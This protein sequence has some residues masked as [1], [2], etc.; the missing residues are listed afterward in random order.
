MPSAQPRSETERG[1]SPRAGH[2]GERAHAEEGRDGG[3]RDADLLTNDER[4]KD[5]TAVTIPGRLVAY[6]YTASISTW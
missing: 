1:V 6:R 4:S 2:C 3:E 5:E